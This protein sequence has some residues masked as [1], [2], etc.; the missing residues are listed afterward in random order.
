M[1]LSGRLRSAFQS[2]MADP[3]AGNKLANVMDRFDDGAFNATIAVSA[4]VSNIVTITIDVT[5]PGNQPLTV[6]VVLDALVVSNATTLAISATDYTTIAATTG[7]VLE[8]VA[9][10]LLKIVTNST[11]RAVLTFTL[12]SGAATNFLAIL[13]PGGA[14]IVSSAITHV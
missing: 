11:G 7:V 13:L 12:A 14:D 10:R 8:V 1:G 9:D 3:G 4:E 5:G 6:P 2:A